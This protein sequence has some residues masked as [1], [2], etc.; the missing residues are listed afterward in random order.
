M[1]TLNLVL[2][3]LSGLV[4][5]VSLGETP[6]AFEDKCTGGAHSEIY[7]NAQYIEEAGD[8]VGYELAL[9]RNGNS[10]S[11]I[12]YDYEGAP[13]EEGVHLTGR[14]VGRKLRLEGRWAGNLIGERAEKQT[15]ETGQATV[16]GSLD[17]SGFR[18]VIKLNDLSTPTKVRMK[19]VKHLWGCK[20]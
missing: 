11:A 1:K 10:L 3:V 20:R 14:L 7:S 19:R 12:L 5:M 2:G 17:S 18:G 9:E 4:P 15:A 13:T 8:V 6:K 16:E